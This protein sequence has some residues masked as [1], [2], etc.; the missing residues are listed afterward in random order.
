MKKPNRIW[1]AILATL[2]AIVAL[3]AASW[4]AGEV[5]ASEFGVEYFLI[6]IASLAVFG[7][8]AFRIYTIVDRD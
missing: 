1:S 3:A 8:A 4:S 2:I 6:L 7:L 5:K